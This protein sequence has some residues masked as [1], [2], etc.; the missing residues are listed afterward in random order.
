[1]VK[2]NILYFRIIKI[3]PYSNI[4]YCSPFQNER[5]NKTNNSLQIELTNSVVL[6]V[7]DH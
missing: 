4:I 6:R 1:M 7:G 3:L 2:M 5:G